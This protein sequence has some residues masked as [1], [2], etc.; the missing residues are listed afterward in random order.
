MIACAK[1][2]LRTRQS[3]PRFR[4]T[5]R[6]RLQFRLRFLD[7]LCAGLL[8]FKIPTIWTI[9]LDVQSFKTL[10]SSHRLRDVDFPQKGRHVKHYLKNSLG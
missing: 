4:R 8:G 10:S 6:L 7:E 9:F 5:T 1:L 2:L 3:K